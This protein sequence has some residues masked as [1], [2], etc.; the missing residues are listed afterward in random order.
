MKR[1]KERGEGVEGFSGFV[2]KNSYDSPK[3]WQIKRE[4]N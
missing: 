4:K 2:T 3:Y 1:Q